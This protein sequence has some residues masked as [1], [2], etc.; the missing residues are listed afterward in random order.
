MRTVWARLIKF[1]YQHYQPA[2]LLSSQ[3]DPNFAEMWLNPENPFFF[4]LSKAVTEFST[5]TLTTLMIHVQ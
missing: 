4:P 1:D 5:E 2:T 3:L